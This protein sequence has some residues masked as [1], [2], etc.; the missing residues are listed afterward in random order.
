MCFTTVSHARAFRSAL[1]RVS[2]NHFGHAPLLS[3]SCAVLPHVLSENMARI[4]LDSDDEEQSPPPGEATLLAAKQPEALTNEANGS[5]S[6]H[7]ERQ[8][9]STSSTGT[10]RVSLHI[11]HPLT[12]PELLRQEI[13]KAHDALVEPTPSNKRTMEVNSKISPASPSVKPPKR[14]KTAIVTENHPNDDD[15]MKVRR[16]TSVNPV[17]STARQS[18]SG[19]ARS[20]GAAITGSSGRDGKSARQETVTEQREHLVD[21]WEVPKSS[22][23]DQDSHISTKVKSR[24]TVRQTIVHG[25]EALPRESVAMAGHVERNEV[26]TSGSQLTTTLQKHV[27]ATNGQPVQDVLSSPSRKRIRRRA[28]IHQ[29]VVSESQEYARSSISPTATRLDSAARGV[30]A[31]DGCARP[32]PTDLS[33]PKHTRASNISVKI[34]HKTSQE[35]IASGLQDDF[36][37]HQPISMFPGDSS[38]VPD[39]TLSQQRLLQ[40][41]LAES[42]TLVVE[43]AKTSARLHDTDSCSIPSSAF[44]NTPLVCLSL[45]LE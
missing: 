7:T 43:Q 8:T 5:L 13:Q 2:K 14:R 44:V 33:T 19:L 10:K 31:E 6:D 34:T 39:N 38:T 15:T 32:R 27:Q 37:A 28:T 4:I 20:N 16:A 30:M 9:N 11:A 42:E 26:G 45:L 3:S 29:S 22:G 17:T 12:C 25:V 41:A 1:P 23:P 24:S 21:E 40:V 36:V 18:S 35:F